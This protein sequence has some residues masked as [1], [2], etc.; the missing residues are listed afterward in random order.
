MMYYNVCLVYKIHVQTL[1]VTQML[2][3]LCTYIQYMYVNVSFPMTITCVS[4]ISD[5]FSFKL[6]VD[7]TSQSNRDW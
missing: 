2:L 6:L 7:Y 3:S 5:S 1:D 4:T